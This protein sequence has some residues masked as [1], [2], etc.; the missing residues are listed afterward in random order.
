[1]IDVYVTTTTMRMLGV[2]DVIFD[3][4]YSNST[5]LVLVLLA[6]LLRLEERRFCH[7]LLLGASPIELLRLVPNSPLDT[8]AGK[9]KLK[10][11]LKIIDY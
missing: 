2:L 8:L 7:S 5:S 3:S 4:V 9:K 6:L 1:M 10:E 11:E